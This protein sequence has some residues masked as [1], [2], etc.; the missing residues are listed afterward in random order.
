MASCSRESSLLSCSCARV[1]RPREKHAAA[2][3]GADVPA[4]AAPA[5]AAPPRA[6][7]PPHPP[8]T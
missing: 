4:A 7:S 1:S 8:R 6:P 5:A 2:A 3:A